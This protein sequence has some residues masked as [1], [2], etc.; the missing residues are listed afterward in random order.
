MMSCSVRIGASDASFDVRMPSHSPGH[1]MA[2]RLRRNP[3]EPQSRRQDPS[4]QKDA[5][6][7]HFSIIWQNI[8]CDRFVEVPIPKL[9]ADPAVLAR[10]FGSAQAAS[11]LGSEVRCRKISAGQ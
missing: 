10:L 2:N 1:V 9:A 8:I 5:R 11:W 4:P 6:P 3:E 7:I